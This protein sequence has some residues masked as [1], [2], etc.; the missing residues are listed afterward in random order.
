MLEGIANAGDHGHAE[1]ARQDSRVGGRAA[2]ARH[3]PADSPSIQAG[4]LSGRQLF[5]HQHDLFH[6]AKQS[7]A[8]LA[9]EVF[10]NA[11]AHVPDVLRP[12]AQ[13]AVAHGLQHTRRVA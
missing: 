11:L 5:P 6:L 13:V 1:R 4:R 2:A 3:D 10:E 7:F 8:L 12:L 9:S